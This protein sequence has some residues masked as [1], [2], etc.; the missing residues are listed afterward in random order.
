MHFPCILSAGAALFFTSS[1]LAVAQTPPPSPVDDFR[2]TFHGQEL[3]DPFHWLEDSGSPE[4]RKWIDAQN[5]YAHGQLDAQPIR[6]EIKSRLTEMMKHDHLGGPL[7]RNGYYY[8]EKRGAEQELWSFFRRKGVDGKDELLLDPSKYSS[9][10]T[11]NVSPFSVSY[12]GDLVAYGVRHGGEDEVELRLLNVT[13][14]ADLPDHFPRGLYRGLAFKRDGKSFYYT[15]QNRDSGQRILYHVLGTDIAKDTEV[16]GKGFGADTWVSP[17]VSEDGRYLLIAV[18]RGWAQSDLYIQNLETGGAIEPLIK[19]LDGKFSPSFS[20]DFLIVETDWKAP[21]GRIL[22]IDLRNPAQ[23]KWREI[24]AEGGDA[25]QDAGMIGGK[26]FVGY[27]HNV[28]SSIRIFSL[29]GK[30]LGEV[31]LPGLGTAGIYG[32]D[33]QSEGILYFSSYTTPYSLF[34]Y[35]TENGKETLWYRDAS[36]F[37][38]EHFETEQVWYS[39]PRM[40][41][42]SRCFSC[43]KRG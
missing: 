5:T 31:Q 9:D 36:P 15:V 39:S 27:L 6:V 18:Q 37:Q 41:R 8:F 20:G 25:I 34:R 3:V 2:E 40:E 19:G 11:A 4:T 23:D 35:D 38:A 26:L 29:E 43:T 28:T 32:R 13:K 12:D 24:V 22:K 33:S 1:L 21:K 42:E 16:F 17:E 10:G 14:H 7:E 30:P